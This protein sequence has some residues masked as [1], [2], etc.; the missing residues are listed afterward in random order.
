MWPTRTPGWE[1]RQATTTATAAPTCSSRT[2]GTRHTPRTQASAP[3]DGRG[4]SFLN[5]QSVFNGALGGRSTVG[6]G[7][8]WVDFTN[9][10]FPDLILANGAIPVTNLKQ[11][12]EPIQVLENLGGTGQPG[13]FANASGIVDRTNLPKIIGRGL[14][15]ADF[16]NNGRM[17]VAINT[18]GGPLVLLQD[19]GPI[20]HWLDVAAGRVPPGAVVTVVLPD[21]RRLVQELHAGSS[22]L[23]SEDPRAHF[24]LGDATKVSELTVR[25][26]D[27]TVTRERNVAANQ[28]VTVGPS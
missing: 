5:T 23:S 20:G 2:P 17:G 21:G 26:P 7:D 6:W 28:I 12:T 15:A 22:Y 1:W 13:Q 18:I 25:W 9:S 19:T 8:S 3:T 24:G 10:G 27:G 4:T 11:D 14:A 16:D